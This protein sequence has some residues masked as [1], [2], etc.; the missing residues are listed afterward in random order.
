M[1][2][3]TIILECFLED[4]AFS[5]RGGFNPEIILH[6]NGPISLENA[7]TAPVDELRR[8]LAM[9]IHSN[10]VRFQSKSVMRRLEIQKG[11]E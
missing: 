4:K 2:S 11:A 1:K 7:L 10:R 3:M 9:E 6:S 8:M 5:V